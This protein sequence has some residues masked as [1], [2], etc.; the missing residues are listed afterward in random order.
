MDALCDELTA[1]HDDLDRIVEGADLETPT[2]A[3]GWTVRDQVTHLWFFDQRALMA[4]TDPDAF[5]L[6]AEE[7]LR[8]GTDRANEQGRDLEP[9]ELLARWRDDRHRLVAHARTVDPKLRVPW[10]GPA[11]GA[12][13][14]ITARLM[15]TWAHG[16]DVA[17]ALGAVRVPTDRLR[18]VAH[19]GVGARPFSYV[20]NDRE[21][22]PAPIR[23]ELVGPSGDSWTWGPEDAADRVSGPALDFCLLVTQRRHR[24]DLA[25][26]AEGAAADEWL[27]IAQSFAGPPGEG[28]RPGQ[29]A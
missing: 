5:R 15:E 23:V 11:M 1:E 18:H 25:V 8:A 14:F 17:D 6:D 10:Y 7:L 16:Q 26:V 3:P 4:L 12:R 9:G 19:I 27:D 2:P 29:F 22:N 24:D 28:R 20:A 21:P 13:S